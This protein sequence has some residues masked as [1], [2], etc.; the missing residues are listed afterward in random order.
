V[1]AEA[2]RIEWV[3]P[4]AGALCCVRLKRQ[5]YGEGAVT[6]FYNELRKQDVRVASGAWFGDEARVFR[7]GFGFLSTPDLRSALD[8]VSKALRQTE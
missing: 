7:L 2:D 6:R 1:S 8:H 3:R 5:R 4:D